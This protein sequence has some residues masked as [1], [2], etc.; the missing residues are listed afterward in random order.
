LTLGG[1][2]ADEN[3]DKENLSPSFVGMNQPIPVLAK[4]FGKNT[5]NNFAKNIRNTG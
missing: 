4:P 1:F 2:K 3:P 5:A